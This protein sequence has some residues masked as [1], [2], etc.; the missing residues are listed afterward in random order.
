MVTEQKVISSL[1]EVDVKKIFSS[2]IIIGYESYIEAK[3][4]K[5]KILNETPTFCK[6]NKILLSENKILFRVIWKRNKVLLLEKIQ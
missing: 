5:T 2:I 4:N 6:R 1:F 3:E